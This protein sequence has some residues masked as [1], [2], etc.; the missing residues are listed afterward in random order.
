MKYQNATLC[1][2]PSNEQETR[3]VYLWFERWES[4]LLLCERR[5][6]RDLVECEQVEI[7]EILAPEEALG[8]LPAQVVMERLI[9]RGSSPCVDHFGSM[10]EVTWIEQREQNTESC[11]KL[12]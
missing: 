3:L 8:E 6:E 5:H 2:S 10:S 4:K 9:R 1:V 12:N 7:Y 11:Q